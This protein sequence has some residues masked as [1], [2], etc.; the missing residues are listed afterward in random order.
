[1]DVLAARPKDWLDISE[2][3]RATN[4]ERSQIRMLW[5]HLSRHLKAHYNDAPWPV[6]A[7]WGSGSTPS[8]ESV[9]FYSLDADQATQWLRVR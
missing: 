6:Q 9:V 3:A 8:R 5:T 4:R 1:M 2:L 7:K